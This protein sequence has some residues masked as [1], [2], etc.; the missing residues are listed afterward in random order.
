LHHEKTPSFFVF[1]YKKYFKCFGCGI[2]GDV[3]TF[4][5]KKTGDSF[6]NIIK[7]L[8]KQL[9]MND[10]HINNNTNQKKHLLNIFTIANIYF[11]HSLFNN[12]GT[13]A[14]NYLLQQR[15]LSTLIIKKWN[16]GFCPP[17]TMNF[18]NCFLQKDYT[19]SDIIKL[20][21]L[22]QNKYGQYPFFYNRIT[23]PIYNYV[24]N[25]IAFGGRIIN[26]NATK[27][28]KYINSQHNILYNKNHVLFH[29]QKNKLS[30]NN[31]PIVL[32]EGY[33]DAI[34]ID[35]VGFV[36][37]ACCGTTLSNQHINFI[38]QFNNKNIVLCFDRDKPGLM[39]SRKAMF[40]L[41]KHNFNIKSIQM[42][43]KDPSELIKLNQHQKLYLYLYNA[44]NAIINDIIQ[45]N[46]TKYHNIYDRI[47]DIDKLLSII[48]AHSRELV[49]RQYIKY[50]SAILGDDESTLLKE[51]HINTNIIQ[52]SIS[53][54]HAQ[55][56]NASDQ[57]LL[58]SIFI[59]PHIIE[60]LSIQSIHAI[61]NN[62]LKQIF[63]IFKQKYKHINEI[64]NFKSQILK[65]FK[66]YIW[67]NTQYQKLIT[68]NV[69][70]QIIKD[71]NKKS[72]L[73][74]QET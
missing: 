74:S 60:I 21:L 15:N 22:K 50:A 37:L 36:A 3:F 12:N 52:N 57:L 66:S 5:Q 51:I 43:A 42:S 9:G 1:S 64:N 65:L 61:N 70:K 19:I 16:I 14:L 33:L 48:K 55:H 38:K 40:I 47:L 39:A 24:G 7:Q 28:P 72:L 35:Q 32:V 29:N 73:K 4:L 68:L 45:I 69:A 30:N 27:Q 54:T 56:L 67:H 8:T 62:K 53:N 49:I 20:G 6:I 23:F 59:F 2:S 25:I 41:A 13:I 63:I 10:K 31:K 11:K 44:K 46:H 34:A 71:F 26:T 17:N 18:I 58:R